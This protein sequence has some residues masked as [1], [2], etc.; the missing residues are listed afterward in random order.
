[1]GLPI[2][3]SLTDVDG[4]ESLT[5]EI[6]NAPAG[7]TFT[8]GVNTVVSE[9]GPLVVSGW[10]LANLELSPAADSDA[11]FD[12]EIRA[13]STEAAGGDSRLVTQSVH[14]DVTGVADA[15]TMVIGEDGP[16]QILEGLEGSPTALPI[17]AALAD[18]DGSESLVIV[19]RGL[20]AGSELS[21]GT[22]NE[23]GTWTLEPGQLEELS[24]RT[25]FGYSGT[26]ALEVDAVSTEAGSGDTTRSTA[27]VQVE[28]AAGDTGVG[29]DTGDDTTQTDTVAESEIV[30]NVEGSFLEGT[31]A[32]FMPWGGGPGFN[33][34]L[35]LAGSKFDQLETDGR[36]FVLSGADGRRF[37][38]PEQGIT[39]LQ[40]DDVDIEIVSSNLRDIEPLSNLEDGIEVPVELPK[41]L[42]DLNNAETVLVSG[43][44]TGAVLSHG[45]RMDGDI[46]IVP[47]RHVHGLTLKMPVHS[48]G[49]IKMKF[50]VFGAVTSAFISTASVAADYEDTGSD[51]VP[52]SDDVTLQHDFS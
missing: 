2:D 19:V 35:D 16:V 3:A 27:S 34:I 25:P 32:R 5:V 11:D 4:S 22:P 51:E 21:T 41:Q 20:P 50:E 7:T 18:V 42:P 29:D 1:M 52:T 39:T 33:T 30:K 15:A 48:T 45:W 28:I 43:V 24:F 49:T 26:F 31:G 46:W 40:L 44:P 10:D 47:P 38:V 13:T 36:E 12:L 9:G 23:D 8:D 37:D 14:V 17:T 6:A